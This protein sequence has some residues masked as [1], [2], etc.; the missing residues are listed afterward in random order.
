MPFSLKLIFIISL[1]LFSCNTSRLEFLTPIDKTLKEVS[2]IAILKSSNLY[3]VIEDAKNSN[4]LYA[5]NSKGH[6][7]KKITITN[8][9]NKDW[10]DLTVDKRNNLYIGDFGNNNFKRKKFAIYKICNIENVIKNTE[11]DKIQFSL[12]KNVKSQDF[13]SFFFVDCFRKVATVG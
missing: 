13:E 9:K 12:P 4:N 11:A 10:E 2:A 7:E 6:I 1:L 8:A 3:W 5:L